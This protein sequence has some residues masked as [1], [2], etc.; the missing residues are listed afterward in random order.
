[1]KVVHPGSGL[2]EVGVEALHFQSRNSPDDRLELLHRNVRKYG[3]I[4]NTVAAATVL[5]GVM[6]RSL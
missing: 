4:S 1:M 2:N 6:R 3:A 5:E